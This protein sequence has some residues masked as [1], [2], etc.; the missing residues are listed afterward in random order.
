MARSRRGRRGI[1][2]EIGLRFLRGGPFEGVGLVIEVWNPQLVREVSGDVDAED[3]RGVAR[4]FRRSH[5]F[6]NRESGDFETFGGGGPFDGREARCQI[7]EF[8]ACSKAFGDRECRGHTEGGESLPL[9]RLV[10]KSDDF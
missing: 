3:T 10:S 4:A 2:F 8:T 5:W 7:L 1:G 6:Q 9:V